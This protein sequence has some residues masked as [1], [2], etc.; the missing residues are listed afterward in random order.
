[1]VLP[2]PR[3][4]DSAPRRRW[5]S[6]RDEPKPP[7]L[8]PD[9]R[10]SRPHHPL[11]NPARRA[12]ARRTKA[13]TR[14]TSTCRSSPRSC[15]WCGRP[16]STRPTSIM[17]MNGALDGTPDALDPFSMYVPE[18]AVT[19]YMAARQ[20][21][22]SGAVCAS[23]R[24]AASPT[25]SRCRRRG[26]PRRSASSRATSSRVS[27]ASRRASCR[28]GGSRRRSPARAGTKVKLEVL[29]AGETRELHPGAR[30]VRAAGRL[31]R[32]LPERAAPARRLLQ[33][34]RRRGGRQ[35]DGVGRGQRAA[36][37]PSRRRVRRRRARLRRGEA[38]RR[39][40]TSAS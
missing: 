24:S 19:D 30:R 6:C 40:A 18:D 34:G 21:G 23:P 3:S 37:R 38:V 4:H 26:R 28:C 17:L 16:T 2:F 7:P 12:D 5:S 22:V 14:S 35:A 29:R 9:L 20:V 8:P 27:T 25:W 15:G 39:R 10:H 1:M 33:Q 11:G 36:G 32:D 13:R 31:R